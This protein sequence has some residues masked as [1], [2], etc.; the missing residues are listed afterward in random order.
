M[1]RWTSSK[2]CQVC[3]N[4]NSEMRFCPKC[5]TLGCVKCVGPAITVKTNCKHCGA[6]GVKLEK[7]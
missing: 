2:P 7:R 5:S 1:G 6:V 4:K 3:G